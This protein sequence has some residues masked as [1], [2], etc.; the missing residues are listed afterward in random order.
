MTRIKIQK[1]INDD[2]N[3]SLEMHGGYVIIEDYDEEKKNLKLQ[4]GGSCQGCAR[5]IYTLKIGIENA[6]RE[7]FPEIKE[8]E[9][10]TDHESGENPYFS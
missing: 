1:F 2:I 9:D 8:I 4:L 7:E 10:V 5:S 6:L 3:P